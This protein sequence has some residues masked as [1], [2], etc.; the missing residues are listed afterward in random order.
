MLSPSRI[1]PNEDDDGG[2]VENPFEVVANQE[3]EDG[4]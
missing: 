4:C 2:A 1:C 3:G